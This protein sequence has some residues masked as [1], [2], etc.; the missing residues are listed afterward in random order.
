MLSEKTFQ[1]ELKHN[2][3][4]HLTEK[5]RGLLDA[6]IDGVLIGAIVGIA[7][8]IF[9]VALPIWSICLICGF[10]PG[11]REIADWNILS[12]ARKRNYEPIIRL[13]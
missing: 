3:L 9:D 8:L 4:I 12:C 13:F 11:L 6:C 2:V 1:R 10:V 5:K 7:S